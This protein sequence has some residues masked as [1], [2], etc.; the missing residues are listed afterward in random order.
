MREHKIVVL[1]AM[2]SGK[3]TLVRAIAGSGASVVDTDVAN[4][5]RSAS[6]HATTVAMDYA[7][8]AL[9]NGERLRLYGTPGQQR[10]D[11]I[12]PVLLQGARG[13]LLLVSAAQQDGAGEVGIYLDALE[14][15]APGI[16]VVVALTQVDLALQQG[17]AIGEVP[18]ML[19]G[20]ALPVLPADARAP[21]QVLMLLD[22]LMAEIEAMELCDVR[23]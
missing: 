18:A 22:M 10:F 15:H 20:R 13:V 9:P 3:T 17:R 14:R 12:W 2:G 19:A 11:F 1:G 21:D 8:I 5:D 4:T 6:K 16:A 23:H 7:D